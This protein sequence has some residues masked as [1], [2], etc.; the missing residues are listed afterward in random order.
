MVSVSKQFWANF[1][2]PTALGAIKEVMP[3]SHKI[4]TTGTHTQATHFVNRPSESSVYNI[5]LA[6][7]KTRK[8]LVGLI[9]N[10]FY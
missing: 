7:I 9:L 8:V 6:K 10:A 2:L 4:K 1:Y 3:T 5:I